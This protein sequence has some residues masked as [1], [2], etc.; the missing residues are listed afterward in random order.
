MVGLIDNDEVKLASLH[1]HL[2]S[3]GNQRQYAADLNSLP[4]MLLSV[5]LYESAGN[6]IF[7]Q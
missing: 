6:S 4:Q 2:V 3:F 7:I 1:A 5:S